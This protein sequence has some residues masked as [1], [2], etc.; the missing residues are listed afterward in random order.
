MLAGLQ[1][2]DAMPAQV[3]LLEM[4]QHG[5]KAAAD[6]FGFPQWVLDHVVP[7]YISTALMFFLHEV[8]WL[9]GCVGWLVSFLIVCLVDARLRLCTPPSP[10]LPPRCS[11]FPFQSN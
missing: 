4:Y 10:R 6:A 8:G 7:A 9:V 1:W 5:L 2:Y 3:L 11:L